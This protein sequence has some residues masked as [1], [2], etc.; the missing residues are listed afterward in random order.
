M[1]V[2]NYLRERIA[3]ARWNFNSFSRRVTHLRLRK[4]STRGR[5]N[6][7]VETSKDGGVVGGGT[8]LFYE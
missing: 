1:K 8:A 4:S 5:C 7:S 6:F 3:K 2:R